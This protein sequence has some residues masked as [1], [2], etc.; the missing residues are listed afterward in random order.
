MP[1]AP[2]GHV[3]HRAQVA[4]VGDSVTLRY[5]SGKTRTLSSS[6]LARWL[7]GEGSP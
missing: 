4:A 2:W 1:R 5:K 6:A 7:S 3:V